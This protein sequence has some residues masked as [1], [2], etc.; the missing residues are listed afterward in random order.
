M[1]PKLL[2]PGIHLVPGLAGMILDFTILLSHPQREE[3]PQVP[4]K[5]PQ[6]CHPLQGVCEG[7]HAGGC[8]AERRLGIVLVLREPLDG[9]VE[10]QATE[11]FLVMGEGALSKSCLSQMSGT[12]G[13][14]VGPGEKLAEL[15]VSTHELGPS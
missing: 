2:Y 1:N 4:M 14:G 9:W 13:Q 8:Q 10:I 3:L 15:V 11:K 6:C 7:T 5:L 12:L